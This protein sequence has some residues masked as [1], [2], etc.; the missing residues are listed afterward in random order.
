MAVDNSYPSLPYL[1]AHVLS[2]VPP[3]SIVVIGVPSSASSSGWLVGAVKYSTLLGGGGAATPAAS[4]GSKRVFSGSGTLTVLASDNDGYIG[5]DKTTVGPTTVTL[6]PGVTVTI[7]DL[8]GDAG[9][10]NITVNAPDGYSIQGASSFTIANNFYSYTFVAF[11][12]STKFGV[13]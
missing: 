2:E 5:I 12:N 9:T 4:S 8:K 6:I 11:P 1:S 13:N 3:D 10:N 7:Q